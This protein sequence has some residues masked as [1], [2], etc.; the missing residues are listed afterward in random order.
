MTLAHSARLARKAGRAAV[1]SLRDNIISERNQIRYD[2][3]ARMFFAAAF[4]TPHPQSVSS[5]SQLDELLM[6]Y[7]EALW[8]EGEPKGWAAYTIAAIQHII[9]SARHRLP[10]AWRLKAA[11][12]RLELPVRAPPLNEDVVLAVAALALDVGHPRSALGILLAFHC[13]LRTGE[14]LA[15]RRQDFTIA[16]TGASAVLNLRLTKGGV[17]RNQHE[18]VTV[19]DPFLARWAGDLLAPLLPGDPIVAQTP[20]KFRGLFNDLLQVLELRDFNFKPYSLR[21]GGA[22]L[23]YRTVGDI[24]A[25]AVRGRWSNIKTARIYITDALAKLQELQFSESQT[26]RHSRLRNRLLAE[27]RSQT[28]GRWRELSSGF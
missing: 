7:V 28:V 2:F 16:R 25:T 22:T 9:P 17:Q 1:G 10:G 18:V 3:F 21:R 15:L 24:N 5:F 13:F 12:D 20:P 26:R 14:L 23:H 8:E 11:W 19:D 6:G 27:V 4:G